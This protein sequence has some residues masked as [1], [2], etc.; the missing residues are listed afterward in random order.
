MTARKE[1]YIALRSQGYS[2]RGAAGAVGCST[3]TAQR[4]EDAA[5]TEIAN[6]YETRLQA[7][8]K[9]YAVSREHLIMRA[10]DVLAMLDDA[11]EARTEGVDLP[12]FEEVKTADLVKLKLKAIETLSRLYIPL[13]NTPGAARSGDTVQV[14]Q[15]VRVDAGNVST[16]PTQSENRYGIATGGNDAV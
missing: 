9:H 10:A 8:Y 14:A 13:H 12:G 15:L 11:T 6:R 4:W 3:S 16:A 1:N 2:L 7:L 5:K